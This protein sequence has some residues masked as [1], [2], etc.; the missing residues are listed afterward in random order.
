[1][2]MNTEFAQSWDEYFDRVR[3]QF[4]KAW[5]RLSHESTPSHATL[6]FQDRV[7]AAAAM[8][9]S[10]GSNKRLFVAGDKSY[11]ALQDIYFS[12]RKQLYQRGTRKTFTKEECGVLLNALCSETV[13]ARN[14]RQPA[15]VLNAQLQESLARTDGFSIE[16]LREAAKKCANVVG[17]QDLHEA[18]G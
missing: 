18:E 4:Q 3:D 10:D 11:T 8:A 16:E 14:H 2:D 7:D 12:L 13:L 5:P 17:S 15:Q 9:W 1:M 6:S